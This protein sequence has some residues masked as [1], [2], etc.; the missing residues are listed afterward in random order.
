MRQTNVKHRGH[1]AAEKPSVM[2]IWIAAARPHTLTAS[3]APTIVGAALTS[4]QLSSSGCSR[5]IVLPAVSFAT[6][7]CLVQ[8]GTNLHNDYADYVKGADTDKRVGHARATQRGWLTPFQTALGA[9]LCLLGAT[10]IGSYLTIL[11]GFD[12]VMALVTASSV[13]NAF[14][15]TGGP[16]PLGYIGLGHISIG[17]AGLGDLFVFLYFGVV[18]TVGVPYICIRYCASAT[19][20]SMHQKG[21]ALL[22]ASL[23]SS[24]PIGLLATA[25]IVVNNLRDRSTDVTAGKKTMCVRF[26]EAFGRAEYAVLIGGSYL[27]LLPLMASFG[28]PWL[29]LPLF[30]LPLAMSEVKS[31]VLRKKDGAAL[32][33]HVGS[34]ARLQ[35]IFC[36][37]LALGMK[38]SSF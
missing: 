35:L 36:L 28:G 7:A 11:W 25:I 9:T 17:Y 33:S 31:I 22:H 30:T 38:L 26:G 1:V 12:W 19:F 24:I 8:L 2:E 15:Y 5:S 21:E 34:T 10:I 16:Y 23:L 13:F 18:A 29:L 4:S 37:L 6:F 3:V 32:N 14:A 20:T 27:T